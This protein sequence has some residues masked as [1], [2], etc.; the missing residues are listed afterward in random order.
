M[1]SKSNWVH[2]AQNIL[3]CNRLVHAEPNPETEIPEGKEIE[4][5]K[6]EIA[7]RDPYEPRLKPITLDNSCKGGYPAWTLRAYGD[8]MIY[9]PAN[10]AHPKENYGVVI[11]R[12]TVWPGAFSYFWQGRWGEVYVGDGHKHDER[13]FFP[14]NPPAIMHD[15]QDKPACPEPNP[16]QEFLDAQA[17]KAAAAKAAA[18]AA[19]AGGNEDE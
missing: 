9:S 13:V 10:P 2:Y 8:Q 4:D 15:P 11:V 1:C 18:E 19:A 6:K 14:V 17:A 12:S 3:K 7:E 5:V 16:T